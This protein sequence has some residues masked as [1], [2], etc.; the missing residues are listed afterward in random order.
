M[1]PHFNRALAESLRHIKPATRFVTL[2][3]DI[4]D[5]PPHFWI[6]PLGGDLICG[7]DRAV[8]QARALHIDDSRI[9]KASGMIIHPR[10]YKSISCDGGRSGRSAGSIPMLPPAWCYLAGRAPRS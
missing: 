10:F 9:Y 1:V 3:T 6:E 5:Y 8:A 4:A 7:S 2:L